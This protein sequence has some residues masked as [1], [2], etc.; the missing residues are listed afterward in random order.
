MSIDYSDIDPFD[1]FMSALALGLVSG[2]GEEVLWIACNEAT[3]SEEFDV[4]I[5]AA[6]D[7]K[8]ILDNISRERR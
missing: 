6:C 7:F 1:I 8:Q 5:N 4:A 3:T 2:L